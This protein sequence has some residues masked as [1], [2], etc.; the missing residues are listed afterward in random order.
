MS[1]ILVIN[2]VVTSLKLIQ[3]RH[4]DSISIT[5]TIGYIGNLV[6][7]HRDVAV[8]NDNIV[9]SIFNRQ[10]LIIDCR[11]TCRYRRKS[12]QFICQFNGQLSIIAVLFRFDTNVASR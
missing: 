4:I 12:G 11:I 9:I 6:A 3:L 5:F 10:A 8:V 2:T 1:V 7:A